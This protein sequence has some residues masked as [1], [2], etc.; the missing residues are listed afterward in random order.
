MTDVYDVDAMREK[1]AG[2]SGIT[3]LI[4]NR[5]LFGI[6]MLTALGGLCYGYEQGSCE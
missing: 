5:R 2:P 1:L 3:D 6:S 4:R